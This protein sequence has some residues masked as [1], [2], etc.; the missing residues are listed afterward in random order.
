M[1]LFS[2]PV[3]TLFTILSLNSVAQSSTDTVVTNEAKPDFRAYEMLHLPDLKNVPLTGVIKIAVVDDGFRLTH[4]TLKNYWYKN[5]NEIPGNGIDDDKNG[6]IDDVCGWDVAD[7]D[8]DVSIPFGREAFFYHGTEVAG[9]LVMVAERCFGTRASEFIKIIPVKVLGDKSQKPYFEHG[10]DGIAY[11]IRQNADIIVCAWSGGKYDPDK[12][13][14]LFEEAK[15]KGITILGS[16]GNFYSGHCDPPASLNSVY[17]IAAVDTS[18]HKTTSSNYGDKIDLSA[19]GE[20]IYAPYP[21]KDNTYSYND[22]TSGAVSLVAGCVTVLKALNPK[23]SPDQLMDALKNTAKP[24]DSLNLTYG[25]KLGAGLPD[26]NAAVNY[27]KTES[28]RDVYFDSR[29]SKGDICIDQ[30]TTRSFWAISPFGGFHGFNFSIKGEWNISGSTIKFYSGDS[31]VSSYSPKSIP[32]TIFVKGNKVGVKYEGKKGAK[33]FYISY[34]SSP[35]DSTTLYCSDIKY[36]DNPEGEISD[37][38]GPFDYANNCACKWQITVP[39]GKHI[40]IQFDEFDTQA[41]TDFVWLFEGTKTLK[42]NTL[43]KFSGPSL[44]PIIISA[45]N[46]VLIWF[47]TDSSITGKGWHLKYKATDEPQGVH[48][49]N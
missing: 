38:S 47:V 11:A 6:Y 16:A 10:Y 42:E 37:G 12:Y 48:P 21:L 29:R 9:T 44:P 34:S 14:S 13:N 7:N 24:L 46:Q 39:E 43:A 41:K 30:S 45:S 28:G 15:R 49:S 22:G 40:K 5:V 2:Y 32:S 23:A 17:A 26:L 25:G 33:P 36:F 35:I 19:S 18:L 27:L 20:L 4:R 3:M 8:P 1:N 31:L